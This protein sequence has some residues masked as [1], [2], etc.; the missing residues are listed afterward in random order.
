MESS[1][2]VREREGQVGVCVQLTGFTAL[3]LNVTLS[4]S[5]D[6]AKGIYPY[7][8]PPPLEQHPTDISA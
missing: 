3:P 2:T 1:F 7:S 8:S 4:T 6:T 5:Q